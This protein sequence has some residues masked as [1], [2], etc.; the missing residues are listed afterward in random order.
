MVWRFLKPG[1]CMRQYSSQRVTFLRPNINPHAPYDPSPSLNRQWTLAERRAL[2]L[3][4]RAITAHRRTRPSFDHIGKSLGRTASECKF[5]YDFILTNWRHHKKL[6]PYMLRTTDAGISADQLVSGTWQCDKETSEWLSKLTQTHEKALIAEPLVDLGKKR[7]WDEQEM[8]D[9]ED[10]CPLYSAPN[11]R[12]IKEFLEKHQ[13]SLSAVQQKYYK[14]LGG[15]M[16]EKNVKGLDKREQE[17]IVQAAKRA[18]PD[19]VRYGHVREALVG[20]SFADVIYLTCR[21]RRNPHNG[22]VG[23]CTE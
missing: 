4:V 10:T 12:N 9:L 7:P 3:Y 14:I 18:L 13:R 5:T 20:R 2:F 8:R 6:T 23:G 11:Q 19:V 21:G 17:V 22:I 1:A 15:A 16:Q